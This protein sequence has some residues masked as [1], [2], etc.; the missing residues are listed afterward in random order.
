MNDVNDF[1]D[2]WS[3]TRLGLLPLVF[4]DVP[5]TYSEG[6]ADVVPAGYNLSALPNRWRYPGYQ[7]LGPLIQCVLGFAPF[8]RSS[9]AFPGAEFDDFDGGIG[10][11]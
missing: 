8:G 10:A 3:W 6:L 4:P 7:M 11:I 9:T 5:Y 1:S 2:F